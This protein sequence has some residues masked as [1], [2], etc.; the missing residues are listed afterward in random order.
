MMVIGD[1]EMRVSSAAWPG[2]WKRPQDSSWEKR[3]GV[4]ILKEDAHTR[5]ELVGRLLVPKKLD[6]PRIP[7]QVSTPG[8][9]KSWV[10]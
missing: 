8:K 2:A 7:G 4:L 9:I 6:Q 3:S 1:P 10:G 5:G